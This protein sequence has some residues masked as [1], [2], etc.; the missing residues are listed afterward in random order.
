MIEDQG[1]ESLE[2]KQSEG[3]G[4]WSDLGDVSYSR[5]ESTAVCM[6]DLFITGNRLR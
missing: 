6:E 3:D 4:F 5:D 1:V 2:R